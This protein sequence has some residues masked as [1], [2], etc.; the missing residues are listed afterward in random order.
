M[1]RTKEKPKVV[2]REGGKITIDLDQLAEQGEE[3]IEVAGAFLRRV[4]EDGGR[5]AGRVENY[6]RD[7]LVRAKQEVKRG[8]Q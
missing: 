7:R 3:T 5:I 4:G 8:R 1:V 6:L 2:R